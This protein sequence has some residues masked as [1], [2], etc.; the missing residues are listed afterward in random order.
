MIYKIHP[1]IGIARLGNSDNFYLAPEQPGVLPVECD[2]EGNEILDGNGQPQR[3]STFKD[4]DLSKIKKQAARFKIYAYDDDED[5]CGKEIKIGGKYKFILQTSV[6][7]LQTVEG[8]VKDIEWTVH[9][10][11]KKA[12]WYEFMETAGS[13]GYA[14]DHPLRNASVKNPDKRRQLI[15]DPGPLTVNSKNST[16]SFKKGQNPGYPQNFPPED[17]K[18]N[19]IDSLGNLM[20]TRQGDHQRLVI[21]G[22]SGNSG[23]TKTPVITSFV[24]NDGW[25]DD[26]SDGPVTAKISFEYDFIYYVGNEKKVQKKTSSM[27]VQVPA[28][29]VV[30]YPRYV[31]E[32]EDMITL[33][34][35][36]YDLYVREMAYAPQIYGVPPYDKASNSPKTPEELVIWQNEAR[37]NPDYFPKFYKELWPMLSRPENYKYTY[38]FD[39][40]A[41]GD[42]HNTGTGGN[43]DQSALSIPPDASGYDRYKVNREFLYRI[44]RMPYQRNDYYADVNLNSNKPRLM[45]MLCGNNPISNT[46]PDKFLSMTK[47]QLFFLGQWANGKF[48]NE[49]EEW[50]ECNKD[51]KNPWAKAPEKGVEIDRGVL[52]NLLGGAFCP[53]GELSWIVENPAIYSEPY[54]I[55]HASYLAGQLSLPKP[56]ADIDGSPAADISAGLEPGDL[57]KYIGIPWQADFHE[58]T[59]QNI[60]VTYQNWNEIYLDSNGDPATDKTVDI[61]WWPAHRPIV[62]QEQTFSLSDGNIQTL[63]DQG[64][65]ENICKKLKPIAGKKF[66][67]MNDFNNVV[68]ANIGPSAMQKYSSQISALA[69]S[70]SQVYWASGLADNHSGDLQMV[71]EW[72]NLGFV[73][74]EDYA[75]SFCQVERNNDA[76]GQ[77]VAPGDR[78]LGQSTNQTVSKIR[79]T[80]R[81]S[82][83]E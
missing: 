83:N 55:K 70:I 1:G 17:I 75:Q 71:E 6:T 41:G 20:V 68:E 53:G 73:K 4:N 16:A 43:F 11:N 7:A 9:L 8:V 69:L 10:A 13:H 32:M 38:D 67:S 47:T 52:S 65:P 63:E 29:V 79:T 62:V 39:Y 74:Y 77:P 61:P 31:P 54:R 76:L 21:L 14:P 12:S 30:G 48:V 22:G 82:G 51:C 42:P 57:T 46:S 15:I 45:P 35:V 80:K 64:V 18:P 59:T 28:W 49:C 40:F 72:K 5:K 58:C 78:L 36:M 23:S 33:D 3:I 27:D 2:A 66:S 19:K 24:N 50:G 44:M 37:F 25:F 81:K 56:V 60:D 26:I 34:E